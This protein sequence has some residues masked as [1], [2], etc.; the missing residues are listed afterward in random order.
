MFGLDDVFHG[1]KVRVKD[2]RLQMTDYGLLITDD[3]WVG[4]VVVTKYK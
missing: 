4:A 3:G 1:G 2:D